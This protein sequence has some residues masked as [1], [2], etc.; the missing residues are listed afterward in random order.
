MESRQGS[1]RHWWSISHWV[2][3]FWRENSV[4]NT[5]SDQHPVFE[6]NLAYNCW[7]ESY[8]CCPVWVPRH[9]NP[10][11]LSVHKMY[12]AAIYF[13]PSLLYV[14]WWWKMMQYSSILYTFVTYFYVEF[15]AFRVFQISRQGPQPSGMSITWTPTNQLEIHQFNTII[16]ILQSNP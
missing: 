9:Q 13:S 4:E 5:V 8:F 6:T 3:G 11:T 16:P 1:D 10:R 12:W 7:L 15:I 2:V 14:C